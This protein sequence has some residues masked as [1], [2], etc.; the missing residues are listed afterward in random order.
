M[1]GRIEA[2]EAELENLHH[3]MAEPDFYRENSET[4][5]KATEDA[6]RL[7]QEIDGL[8]HRWAELEERNR[9]N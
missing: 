4:I 5:R 7:P 6:E 2:L 1:P 8:L 3:R 9:D